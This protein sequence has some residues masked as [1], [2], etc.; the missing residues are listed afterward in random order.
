[1]G[2]CRTNR[3]NETNKIRRE[4]PG[5][6]CQIELLDVV[7]AQPGDRVFFL[8]DHLHVE[9][10]DNEEHLNGGGRLHPMQLTYGS[11]VAKQHTDG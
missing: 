7:V 2:D 10:G 11:A 8:Q 5:I 9:A 4:Q 1:M 6:A 3:Q